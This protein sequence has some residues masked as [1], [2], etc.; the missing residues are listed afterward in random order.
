MRRGTFYRYILTVTLLLRPTHFVCAS[1]LGV[2]HNVNQLSLWNE[3]QKLYVYLSS[4]AVFGGDF[5]TRGTVKPPPQQERDSDEDHF[6]CPPLHVK[7]TAKEGATFE[8]GCVISMDR[9]G[10]EIALFAMHCHCQSL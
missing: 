2:H 6:C 8:I 9:G 4:K 7:T 3:S 1:L 5:V 10:M